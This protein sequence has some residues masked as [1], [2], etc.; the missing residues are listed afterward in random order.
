VEGMM[1]IVTKKQARWS[2][3]CPRF[4]T[5]LYLLSSI[6]YIDP[7]LIFFFQTGT[8]YLR[9]LSPNQILRLSKS[10]KAGPEGCICD[11]WLA[12]GTRASKLLSGFTP[13]TS[14]DLGSGND[15]GVSSSEDEDGGCG[16]ESV[17]FAYQGGIVPCS[18]S[19]RHCYHEVALVM[20][21]ML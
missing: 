5:T 16:I 6:S 21:S 12:S 7:L 11:I 20:L 3:V 18:C 13:A 9:T 17:Y 14:S 8:S 15:E 4:V 2:K 10:C 1:P 19:L